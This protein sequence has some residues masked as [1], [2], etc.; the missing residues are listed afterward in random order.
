MPPYAHC[1]PLGQST[2]LQTCEDI[3]LRDTETDLLSCLKMPR[4]LSARNFL[5]R[6]EAEVENK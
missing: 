4:Q 2:Q 1:F 3:T 5:E 6:D